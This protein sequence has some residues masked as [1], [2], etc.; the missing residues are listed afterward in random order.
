VALALAAALAASPAR[1]GELRPLR[2]DPA[3]SGPLAGGAAG[4]LLLGGLLREPLGPASCRSCSPNGFDAGAREALV[5]PYPATARGLSGALSAALVVGA[6]T[7]A[8]LVA[9]AGG[10]PRSGLVDLLVIGEASLVALDVALVLQHAT[11]RERPWVHAGNYPEPV[12]TP[13]TADNLSFPSGQT[14]LAFSVATAAGTVAFLRGWRHAPWVLGVGLGLASV[15]GYLRIAGDV[16]WTTDVLA[17]A[18]LGGAAGFGMPWLL[19]R[20]EGRQPQAVRVVPAPG[21]LAL[22]F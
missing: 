22:L 17:G 13:E 12:R 21:G 6:G 4:L 14:T 3:V 15:V 2:W 20:P 1:A 18:A 7:E 11:G 19:H 5:L 8:L 10:D 9:R 16:S